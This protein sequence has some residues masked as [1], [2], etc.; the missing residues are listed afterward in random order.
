MADVLLP[1]VRPH[2]QR[3]WHLT[4]FALIGAAMG[5]GRFAANFLMILIAGAPEMAFVLYLPMFVSQ[6]SFGAISAFVTIGLLDLLWRGP[7]VS[8]EPRTAEQVAGDRE[9]PGAMAG[10]GASGTHHQSV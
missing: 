4:Q 2:S 6:V 10:R 8:Q 1:L 3:W 7:T 9:S 5:A